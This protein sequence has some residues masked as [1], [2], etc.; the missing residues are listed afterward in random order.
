[1]APAG[2]GDLDGI[3]GMDLDGDGELDGILGMDLDGAG[4]AGMVIV[5]AGMDIMAEMLFTM[6]EEEADQDTTI[7]QMLETIDFLKAELTT[8]LD[9]I[10]IELELHLEPKIMALDH[11]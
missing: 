5:G 8:H 7:L 3:L 9:L 2:D 6:E 4:M 10:L 1:M 11:L